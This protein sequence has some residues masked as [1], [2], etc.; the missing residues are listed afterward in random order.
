MLTYAEVDCREAPGA[1]GG[2]SSK[3]TSY[4]GGGGVGAGSEAFENG[5]ERSAKKARKSAN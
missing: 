3:E 2:S 5:E 4:G 1:R